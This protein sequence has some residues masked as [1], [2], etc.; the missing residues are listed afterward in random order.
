MQR[1]HEGFVSAALAPQRAW[2][3]DETTL[4][5][6]PAQ[7]GL[8]GGHPGRIRGRGGRWIRESGV[9]DGVVDFDA[10]LRDPA[11]PDA[12]RKT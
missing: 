3:R 6:G 4:D 8:A 2:R 12:L 7:A 10:A 1:S 11:R 9:F 5:R